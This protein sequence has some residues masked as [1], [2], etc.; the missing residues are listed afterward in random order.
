[1]YLYYIYIYIYIY[2]SAQLHPHS[3]HS[4]ATFLLKWRDQNSQIYCY[5]GRVALS[6]A[7]HYYQRRGLSKTQNNLVP[8]PCVHSMYALFL[9]NALIQR[10]IES[11]LVCRYSSTSCVCTPGSSDWSPSP[12]STSPP[13]T[14]CAT[15]RRD[16][17]GHA[18]WIS[19]DPAG[20]EDAEGVAS[21]LTP[22]RRWDSPWSS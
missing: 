17:Q 22:L 10:R 9:C 2:I 3:L 14:S 6:K 1:M 15:R 8:G 11:I 7:Y 4:H 18:A 20:E 19:G 13:Q 12:P 16:V 21:A 5:H